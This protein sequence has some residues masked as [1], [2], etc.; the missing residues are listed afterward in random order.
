[1]SQVITYILIETDEPTEHLRKVD[2]LQGEELAPIFERALREQHG[3]ERKRFIFRDNGQIE[4]R[5]LDDCGIDLIFHAIKIAKQHV[6][7]SW[8]VKHEQVAA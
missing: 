2:V 7:Q 6:Y 4:L 8:A 5:W 1:M 3:G